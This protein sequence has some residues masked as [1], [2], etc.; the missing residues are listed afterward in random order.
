MGLRN[1][2]TPSQSLAGITSH[3]NEF[4]SSRLSSVESLTW[5]H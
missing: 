5:A 4:Y 1:E 3:Y 2:S